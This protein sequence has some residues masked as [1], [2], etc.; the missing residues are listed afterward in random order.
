MPRA[1]GKVCAVGGAP[2]RGCRSAPP[3]LLR[4]KPTG[5][6]LLGQVGDVAH[7]GVRPTK[8]RKS[9]LVVIHLNRTVLGSQQDGSRWYRDVPCTLP[10]PPP[11]STSPQTVHSL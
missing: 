5:V 10:L 11:L 8:L 6:A 2:G 9:F 4:Q 7:C 3:R 1:P